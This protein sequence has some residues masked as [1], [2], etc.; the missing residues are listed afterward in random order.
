MLILK[1]TMQMS[2]TAGEIMAMTKNEALSHLKVLLA[3]REKYF[4]LNGYEKN[5]FQK[6]F[7]ELQ[8][9]IMFLKVNYNIWQDELDML[10]VRFNYVKELDKLN[11][12]EEAHKNK[13]LRWLSKS[14]NPETWVARYVAIVYMQLTDPWLAELYEIHELW[15]EGFIQCPWPTNIIKLTEDNFDGNSNCKM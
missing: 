7:E 1:S 15:R 3:R 14:F 11:I 9:E 8:S 4:L 5:I 6:Q 13:E 2:I 12:C 10:E